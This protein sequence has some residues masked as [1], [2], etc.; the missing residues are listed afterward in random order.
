[1][2]GIND[3]VKINHEC[4][5]YYWDISGVVKEIDDDHKYDQFLYYIEFDEPELLGGLKGEY[6]A[7]EEL[8]NSE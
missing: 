2:I 4:I 1:M 5:K 8:D 3:R 6:F 7:L